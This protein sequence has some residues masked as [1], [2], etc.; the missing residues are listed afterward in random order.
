MPS[1]VAE[2][3]VDLSLGGHVDER[4]EVDERHGG[5]DGH[6]HAQA[7]RAAHHA[8]GPLH[9]HRP[10]VNTRLIGWQRRESIV[11]RHH[12]LE[13]LLMLAPMGDLACLLWH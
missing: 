12:C 8:L 9:P 13:A 11:T 4:R 7:Q 3:G 10:S 1:H 5:E 6:G 2:S